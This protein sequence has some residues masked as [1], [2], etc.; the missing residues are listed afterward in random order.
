MGSVTKQ[1]TAAVIL[2]LVNEGAVSLDSTI[3]SYLPHYRA[4]TGRQ[5]TIHHLLC[6]QSG[7]PNLTADPEY[8]QFSR[9]PF[10]AEEIIK[11]RC[12]GNLEFTP[13]AEF[14]YSNSNY[15]ILGGIIEAVT[16][17]PYEAVLRT[18]IFDPLHMDASGYDRDD[19]IIPHRA[20]GYE[21]APEG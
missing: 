16:G 4:D 19:L 9:Q 15:V 18:R 12:S 1:F 8:P 14:R 10:S 6:H 13:G 3:S 21:P 11:G 2:Q 7:I 17:T 5:V 20:R